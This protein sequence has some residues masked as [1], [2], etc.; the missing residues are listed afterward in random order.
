MRFQNWLVI[1]FY[2]FQ[3]LK[4]FKTSKIKK[5]RSATAIVNFNS[6]KNYNLLLRQKLTLF[7]IFKNAPTFANYYHFN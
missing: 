2:F 4:K 3:P 5:F 1:N 6:D 7:Y